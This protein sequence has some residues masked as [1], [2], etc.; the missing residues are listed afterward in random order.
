MKPLLYA[1]LMLIVLQP[2]E[3]V[4]VQQTTNWVTVALALIGIIPACIAAW[5]AQMGLSQARQNATVAAQ[6]AVEVKEVKKDG[7]ANGAKLTEIHTLT[8]SNLTKVQAQLEVSNKTIEGLNLAQVESARRMASMEQ[9]ITSLIPAKGT[10]SPSEA[11][12]EKLDNLHTMLSNVQSGTPPIP[13][14]DEAVLEKLNDVVIGKLDTIQ[15]TVDHP[16]A[17]PKEKVDN[18]SKLG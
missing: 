18:P 3:P 15:E 12:G 7:T 10:Q 11:N 17:D 16:A 6:T 2:S 9:L 8:N 5:I 4:L 13:V 14:R 1:L